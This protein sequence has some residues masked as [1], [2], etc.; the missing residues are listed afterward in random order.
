MEA[1]S[2]A[3]GAAGPEVLRRSANAYLRRVRNH[4]AMHA[5]RFPLSLYRPTQR[6]GRFRPRSLWTTATIS[7]HSSSL[8]PAGEDDIG[9]PYIGS[10]FVGT[11]GDLYEWSKS[12]FACGR[13]YW[14]EMMRGRITACTTG[15]VLYGLDLAVVHLWFLSCP[16]V[17]LSAPLPQPVRPAGGS[18]PVD[19]EPNSVHSWLEGESTG[20]FEL[21]GS[22]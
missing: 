20:S 3:V 15:F 5:L 1:S 17:V 6:E 22:T 21:L 14:N 13:E 7:A 4:V 8:R 9:N 12:G 16:F 2:L 11:D 10:M 19:D 18:G